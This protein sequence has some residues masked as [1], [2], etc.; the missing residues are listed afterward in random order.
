MAWA[1]T[2]PAN[3]PPR[4]PSKPSAKPDSSRRRASSRTRLSPAEER[5]RAAIAA[6]NNRI[7]ET[8]ARDVEH[9]GMA[10]VLTLAMVEDGQITIG[11]VGDSRLYLIWNG[12]IRKLTSDHSPV[13]QDEDAGELT[14]EQAMLH[15]R[16]NEVFRDVGTALRAADDEGFIEDPQV[17]LPS[18]RGHSVVQR[19]SYRPSERGARAR[20]RGT[21]RWRRRARGERTGG[22]RQPGRRPRQHHRAFRRR[23]GVPR[24]LRRHRARALEPRASVAPRGALT[25]R[26]AFLIYGLLI[27]MLLWAVDDAVAADA[28]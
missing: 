18:R 13:G 1:A 15:P 28:R 3:W 14:E 8:A 21:L 19:R 9:K 25:G 2:P 4:P 26:A 7:F 22:G 11:H 10:C 17:P 5:V 27:G 6:A 12:A 20:N 23:A 16:R 24:T